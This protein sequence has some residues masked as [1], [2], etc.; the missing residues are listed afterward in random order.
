MAQIKHTPGPLEV[1]METNQTR[2]LLCDGCIA[3]GD[4]TD[5]E[6][7]MTP[8]RIAFVCDNQHVE[9]HPIEDFPLYVAA[10]ELLNAL[11]QLIARCDSHQVVP[12]DPLNPLH[13]PDYAAAVEAISKAIPA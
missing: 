13:D 4:T 8:N 5:N 3:N 11:Q 1:T 9:D 7:V 6:H 2:Q 12:I 10:P